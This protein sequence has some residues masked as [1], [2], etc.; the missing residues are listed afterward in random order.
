MKGYNYE[1][2]VTGKFSGSL[3]ASSV[4]DAVERLTRT[5]EKELKKQEAE[6]MDL[7]ITVEEIKESI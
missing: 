5:Y 1:I 6:S 2:F 7:G 3:E 4:D